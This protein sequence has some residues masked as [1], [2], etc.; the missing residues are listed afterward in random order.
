MHNL[1]TPRST[2]RRL[3]VTALAF[4]AFLLPVRPA[5][6]AS[7]DLDPAFSS[8][9]KV[10]TDLGRGADASAVAVQSDGRIVVAG[11]QP[12]VAGGRWFIARYQPNGA[13]DPSFS[14]DGIAFV[15]FGTGYDFLGDLALL[16]DGRIVVVGGAQG[17]TRTALARL[18]PDGSL[19]T[20]FGVGGK[21]TSDFIPLTDVAP[22]YEWALDV[23]VLGDG[24]L[25]L[26]GG[27]GNQIA[28][29]AFD[30]DGAVDTGFSD[31]GLVRTNVGS[32]SETGYDLAVADDGTMA[33]TGVAGPGGNRQVPIIRY[34][35]DGSPDTAFA[36]DGMLTVDYTPSYDDGTGVAVLDDGRVLI[37]GEADGRVGLSQFLPDGSPDPAFS[38]DGRQVLDLSG[39][40]EFA[41]RM[42]HRS[43]GSIVLAGHIGGSGGRMLLARLDADG[44]RDTSFSGNGVAEVNFTPGWDTAWAVAE[45]ADGNF[46]LAGSSADTTRVAL[47]RVLAS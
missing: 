9:G 10:V 4:T 15:N 31:D 27:A 18:G 45:Q 24:S 25:R 39:P 21:R 37:A 34:S 2:T 36:G 20:T 33:V 14:S 41:A 11:T 17:S 44:S 5:S 22:G 26:T 46:V 8:D 19:D 42:L 29:T 40:Y 12:G 13:L 47:A 35:A 7:G 3:A 43:D 38:G 23:E 30:P 1:R 16:D 28:L 6:A 32:G